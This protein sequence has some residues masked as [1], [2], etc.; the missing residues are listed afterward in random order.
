M[1]TEEIEQRIYRCIKSEVRKLK[2]TVLAINGM[3]DHV[4]LAARLPGNVAP[5][6]LMQRA[7]GVSSTFCHQELVKG[8]M[9]GW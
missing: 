9:F 2:G 7:K 8:G 3:P 6:L 5:S 4:H 1:V